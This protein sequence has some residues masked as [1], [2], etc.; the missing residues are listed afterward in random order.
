MV[1]ATRSIILSCLAPIFSLAIAGPFFSIRLDTRWIDAAC[2]T[3]PS[4]SRIAR[5]PR[6]ALRRGFMRKQTLLTCMIKRRADTPFNGRQLNVLSK[7]YRHSMPA[8]TKALSYISGVTL[9]SPYSH[10]RD[11]AISHSLKKNISLLMGQRI[12]DG[13]V[14][15]AADHHCW[16]FPLQ[17]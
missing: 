13:V 4:K 7:G 8:S 5:I 15:N 14:S 17:I 10:S 12:D 6:G 3:Q 1:A 9:K 2:Q 16:S 11:S